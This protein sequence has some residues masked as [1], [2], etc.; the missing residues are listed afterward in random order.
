MRPNCRSDQE[1]IERSYLI[2]HCVT[3][4]DSASSNLLSLLRNPCIMRL[5]FSRFFVSRLCLIKFSSSK[6][7]FACIS[8]KMGSGKVTNIFCSHASCITEMLFTPKSDKKG[9][10]QDDLQKT[11]REDTRQCHPSKPLLHGSGCRMNL[12]I[13]PKEHHAAFES[14]EIEEA[15]AEADMG[16]NVRPGW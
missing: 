3:T 7:S 6:D 11:H 8:D 13:V 12:L 1:N 4:V 14:G 5:I 2:H 9:R 15:V 16:P 10:Y